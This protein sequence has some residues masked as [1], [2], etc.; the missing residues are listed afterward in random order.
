V[1]NSS[2][3]TWRRR[4]YWRGDAGCRSRRL[5]GCGVTSRS[6][7]HLLALVVE[8]WE[9]PELRRFGDGARREGRE[10]P[11]GYGVM[12]GCDGARRE[13]AQLRRDAGQRRRGAW[14]R[15]RWCCTPWRQQYRRERRRID[16]E[17]LKTE[18]T[19][20]RP[21]TQPAEDGA[22]RRHRAAYR[23]LECGEM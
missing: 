8:D 22:R 17:F 3:P 10:R 20:P 14:M 21:A 18:A 4:G 13:L 12:M 9:P 2:T 7:G 5:A 16:D 23:V 11:S 15:R 19:W 6:R 1:L